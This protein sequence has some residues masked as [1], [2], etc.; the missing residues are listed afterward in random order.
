MTASTQ[1]GPAGSVSA[2]RLV[3]T[4]AIDVA[5]RTAG[6]GTAPVVVFIHG[7][8][9][10]S[11]F[12]NS[13]MA[14]LAGE[15]RCIAPDLR[16]FGDTE[17]L[18]VSARTGIADMAGDVLA[19]CD[20]L[21]LENPHLVGHSMGGGVAMK[22]LTQRPGLFASVTLVA[23]ISPYGYGG[24]RDEGGTPCFPDGAG[25]GAGAVNADLVASLSNR[26]RRRDGGAATPRLV[27]EQLYFKPPFVAD[28]MEEL[29]DGM[30]STRIG[31]DW[32]P[33]NSKPSDNWPGFS[34]G[35]AGVVNAMSGRYFDASGIAV[36]E[37]KPSLLWVRGADDAIISD[38]S[39]LDMATQG[40]LGNVPGWP[41]M[42]RCPPQPMLRQTRAVL[43]AYAARGGEVTEEVIADC[44]HTP[45]IEKPDAF[46]RLLT[47]FL[48]AHRP[49][50]PG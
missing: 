12:W 50:L 8:L 38:R 22:M 25:A 34:P 1:S 16:G 43:A 9:S 33:G 10:S 29:L 36:V 44:G 14:A 17:A 35:D 39:V 32:Y 28:T 45:F 5:I 42:E 49:A 6:D 40:A 15:F 4:P 47:G 18:A 11:V 31:D 46:V 7:N 30:L 20:N 3:R 2:T 19:V 27:M 21:G 23:P 24:T 41:G 26:S 48:H 13:T 37:P